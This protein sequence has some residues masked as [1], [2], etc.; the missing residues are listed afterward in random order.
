MIDVN[1]LFGTFP[2]T[3]HPDEYALEA[4]RAQLAS[5]GI[6]NA[7]VC[8]RSGAAFRH[9]VG[10]DDTFVAASADAAGGPRLLP[11]ATINPAQNLGWRDELRRALAG[12]AVALRLFPDQ[13]GWEY[14]SEAFHQL[15]A[16]LDGR[17]PL[18]APVTRFGDASRIGAATARIGR[19]V[20]LLGGH[21][22]QLG[23]CLAALERWPH[24]HLE[25]SRL[26]Q[27]KGVETVTRLAG[28][29]RLLFGSGCPE[30][31]IQAVLNAIM[32]ARIPEAT[33][34][35]ILA[36]NAA[37]L[38]G[39][40]L[41]DFPL[42]AATKATGLIDVHGHVGPIRFPTP[43]IE[44]SALPALMAEHGVTTTLASS[45]RAIMDD[46]P[47]GN[48]DALEAARASND[49]LHAYVVVN[50]NDLEGSCRAMDRAYAAGAVGAK[51]H[52]QWSGQP[53]AAPATRALLQEVAR[54][55]RP[56]K[57]H[58]DGPGWGAAIVEAARAYPRWKV[59]VAHGG[60][61]TPDAEGAWTVEHA[62][63]VYLELATTAPDLPVVRD[64]VRRVGPDRLLL[65]TDVP[66]IDPAYVLGMYADAGADLARTAAVAREVFGL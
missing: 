11:V 55:E 6:T 17:V 57:V 13:Q 64:V 33:R 46:A 25:T 20:V 53:T 58:N 51:L 54:R 5:H 37:R 8:A 52:C 44:P 48:A 38:F 66:L 45:I 36:G 50:P 26:G 21:Y 2:R 4:A 14:D 30:K 39:I 9:E 32:A 16:A 18:L 34:R 56:L 28:A 31:P 42:P 12:G 23:D 40:A 22:T 19:P 63:N 60:P 15:V 10:N 27:F 24:L 59:I 35:A 43:P 49:A 7:L 29:E 1:V 65:G 61:G 47:R 41:P 3:A 62:D